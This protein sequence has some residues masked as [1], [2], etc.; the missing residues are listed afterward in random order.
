[1]SFRGP[2]RDKDLCR[3]ILEAHQYIK[4]YTDGV[5]WEEFSIDR[6]TQDAVAMR[7]QQVLECASKFSEKLKMQL[8]IKWP[9]MVAMRNK[10]SHSYEDIDITVIWEVISDLPEFQQFISFAKK[11]S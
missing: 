4:Q 2:H 7:L 6:K 11:N 9:N 5:T 8:L 1:M 10:I 3:N